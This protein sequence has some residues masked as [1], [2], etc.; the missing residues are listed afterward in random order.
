MGF[1]KTDRI[2]ATLDRIK[3]DA[4]ILL[5]R[6]DKSKRLIVPLALLPPGYQERDCLDITLTRDLN[7]V[8]DAESRISSLIE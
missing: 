1:Q 3:G 8:E 5:I 6:N 7:A 2:K 4:A